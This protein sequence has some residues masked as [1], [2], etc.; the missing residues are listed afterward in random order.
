MAGGDRF[1]WL[2]Q[3]QW[4]VLPQEEAQEVA[5]EIVRVTIAMNNSRWPPAVFPT[6]WNP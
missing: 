3:S 2:F 4:K 6:G 5:R 1:I